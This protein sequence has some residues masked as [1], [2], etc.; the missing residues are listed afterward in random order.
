MG[1]VLV[2]RYIWPEY[3]C[4]EHIVLGSKWKKVSSET[5]IGGNEIF[6]SALCLALQEK[7]LFSKEEVSAFD[8]KDLEVDSFI[9]VGDE[10]FVQAGEGQGWEAIVK[11]VY[12]RRRL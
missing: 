2:P 10:Y 7:Q 1:R 11:R 3:P 12:P 9:R 4:N 5:A 8:L 6:C